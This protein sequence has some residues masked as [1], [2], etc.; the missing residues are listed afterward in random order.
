MKRSYCHI[1]CTWMPSLLCES[2][3]ESCRFIHVSPSTLWAQKNVSLLCGF[4]IFLPFTWSWEAHG[5]LCASIVSLPVGVILLL[6][7]SFIWW[8]EAIVTFGALECFLS[9]VSPLMKPHQLVVFLCFFK[10]PDTE[11]LLSHFLHCFSPVW[12]LMCH[13]FTWSREAKSLL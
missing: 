7:H 11:K 3:H 10:S 13:Q 8:R 6:F 5:R 4:P 1:W 12:S 2:S 9:H